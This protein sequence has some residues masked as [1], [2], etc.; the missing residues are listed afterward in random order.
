[1]GFSPDAPSQSIPTSSGI[2]THIG[3]KNLERRLILL[4]GPSG[5][6]RITSRPNESTVVSFSI[7]LRKEP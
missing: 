7:P 3:L 4:Y 2:H 5:S 1:M 6:L